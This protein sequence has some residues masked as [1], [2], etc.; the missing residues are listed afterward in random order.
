[1]SVTDMSVTDVPVTDMSVTDISV[2]GTTAPSKL[3]KPNASTFRTFLLQISAQMPT[4]LTEIVLVLLRH[5]TQ[6][7]G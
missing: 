7:P 2:T 5:T 6:I 1:M 3:T 4:V